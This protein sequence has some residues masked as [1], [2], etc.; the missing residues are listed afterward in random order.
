[1]QTLIKKFNAFLKNKTGIKVAYHG[2]LQTLEFPSIITQIV[3]VSD[4]VF[5]YRNGNK[6]TKSSDIVIQIDVFSSDSLVAYDTINKVKNLLMDTYDWD[7][8]EL[9]I[10]SLGDV[11][12]LSFIESGSNI[13]RKSM[14]ITVEYYDVYEGELIDV[15]AVEGTIKDDLKNELNLEV[16]K[17][18]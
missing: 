16:I 8:P 1:M 14:D 9:R 15:E 2:Q 11:R 12:D 18:D 5:R 7:V 17:E 4:S 13:E 6:R 10:R 3:N